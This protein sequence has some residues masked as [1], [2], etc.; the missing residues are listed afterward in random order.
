LEVISPSPEEHKFLLANSVTSVKKQP[1]MSNLPV[2]LFQE[3][4]QLTSLKNEGMAYMAWRGPER[5]EPAATAME[6][7][8]NE[9]PA[10]K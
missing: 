3:V 6:E 7:M 8:E 2:L 10:V 1:K 5:T 4:P 9:H